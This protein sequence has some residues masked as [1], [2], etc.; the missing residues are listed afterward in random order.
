MTDL[1]CRLVRTVDC[2]SMRK[3]S[4]RDSRTYGYVMLFGG[5]LFAAQA[6]DQIFFHK[7]FG[8]RWLTAATALVGLTGGTWMIVKRRPPLASLDDWVE[9]RWG[10]RG[11][12]G[13][14]AV[15]GALVFASVWLLS[16]LN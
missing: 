9:E 11:R 6:V 7:S 16:R 13:V 10:S 3:E 2:R 14:A 12:W 4:A 8:L 15:F 5:L 1:L